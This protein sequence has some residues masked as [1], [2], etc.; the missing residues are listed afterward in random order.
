MV[1]NTHIGWP[2]TVCNS[3]SRGPDPPS[4]VGTCT[5]EVHTQVYRHT[6]KIKI[7]KYFLKSCH[8]FFANTS[9]IKL[10]NLGS[11]GCKRDAGIPLLFFRSSPVKI[12]ISISISKE[13]GRMDTEAGSQSILA[14][15]GCRVGRLLLWTWAASHNDSRFCLWVRHSA[16]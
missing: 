15:L 13:D 7:I 2:K 16:N 1:L 4:S 8:A 3:S 10:D 12:K 11:I 9:W 6:C 14:Q 5:H